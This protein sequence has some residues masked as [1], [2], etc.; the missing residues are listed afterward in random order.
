M[1][2]TRTPA[3]S[4][5]FSSTDSTDIGKFF[6]TSFFARLSGLFRRVFI[7]S[8]GLRSCCSLYSESSTRNFVSTSIIAH[9]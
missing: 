2:T 1:H 5:M 7:D 3:T 9:S 4:Y 6:R 8:M